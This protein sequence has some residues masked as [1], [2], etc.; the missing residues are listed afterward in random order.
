MLQANQAYQYIRDQYVREKAEDDQVVLQYCPTKAMK[1]NL[2]TKLKSAGQFKDLRN[3]L[4]I[5]S[6]VAAE[7]SGSAVDHAPRPESDKQRVQSG[8]Y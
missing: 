6:P 1:A 8:D 7:S 4:G 2:M 5:K 3:K